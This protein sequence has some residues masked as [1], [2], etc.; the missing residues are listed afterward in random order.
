MSM[1]FDTYC[2]NPNRSVSDSAVGSRFGDCC[3]VQMT[4]IPY[5]DHLKLKLNQ[6]EYVYD[7]KLGSSYQSGTH[8][9]GFPTQ[10]N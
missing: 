3:H 9:D 2:K 8:V 4:T 6:L 7:D 1:M 10:L 5:L